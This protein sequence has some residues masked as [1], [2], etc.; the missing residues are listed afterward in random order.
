MPQQPSVTIP[1]KMRLCTPC[2]AVVSSE[3]FGVALVPL[4]VPLVAFDRALLVVVD[5]A[6][7]FCVDFRAVFFLRCFTFGMAYTQFL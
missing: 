6:V 4:A 2:G 7:I 1:G 3:R 5:A